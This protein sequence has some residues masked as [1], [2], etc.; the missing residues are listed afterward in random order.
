MTLHNFVIESE[1]KGETNFPPGTPDAL[2]ELYFAFL[3]DSK[4]DAQFLLSNHE[5]Q[6]LLD[7]L[8][9]SSEH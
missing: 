8:H 4:D 2:G 1:W 7:K 9:G 6:D 5:I 3:A